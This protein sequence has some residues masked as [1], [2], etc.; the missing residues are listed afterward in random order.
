MAGLFYDE[1]GEYVTEA[2]L[3]AEYKENEEYHKRNGD[4]TFGDYI[5]NCCS[6]NGTLTLCQKRNVI[7]TI[8]ESEEAKEFCIDNNIKWFRTEYYDK[9]YFEIEGTQEHFDLFQ[10]FLDTMEDE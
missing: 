10:H 5:H 8:E 9:R 2:Q 6:K 4:E 7:L 1:R 3:Y